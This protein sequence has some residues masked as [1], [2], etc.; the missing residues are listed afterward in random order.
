MIYTYQLNNN[1]SLETKYF[2]SV[3]KRTFFMHL[4]SIL[5]ILKCYPI[6]LVILFFDIFLS[7][8]EYKERV[9]KELSD[10]LFLSDLLS[11]TKCRNYTRYYRDCHVD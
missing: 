1:I 2:T 10:V 3:I 11:F 9:L 4:I 8:E 5:N 7:Y 6:V